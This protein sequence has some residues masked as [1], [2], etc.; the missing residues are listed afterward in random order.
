MRL[1]CITLNLKGLTS[2]WFDERFHAAI[3]NLKPLAPDLICVQETTLCHDGSRLYNQ[4][5]VIGD[6]TGLPVSAFAPY[7][8]PVEIM[9]RERGGIG[10]VSRWPLGEVRTRRLCSGHGRDHD[11]RVSIFARLMAPE[12]AIDVATTHLSWRPEEAETRLI[13][14]GMVLEELRLAENHSNRQVLLGDFNATED[15]PAIRLISEDFQDAFR[16]MNPTEPGHTWETRNAW[17]QSSGLPDR[18]VDYIFCGKSAKI[19]ACRV[20]LNQA[21]PVFVSDHYGVIADLE[22]V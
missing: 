4:A 22:W 19:H 11:S 5:Q 3:E 12:G 15:E 8:N 1:R 17:A 21:L 18:R 10:L 13:Q 20:I 16:T 2:K 14:I 9:S 6:A 7:G